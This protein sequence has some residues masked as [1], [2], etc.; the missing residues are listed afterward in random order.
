MYNVS[1]KVL[2]LLFAPTN[3]L[4]SFA[5]AHTYLLTTSYLV[6]YERVHTVRFTFCVKYLKTH[7][8]CTCNTCSFQRTQPIIMDNWRGHESS[9]SKRGSFGRDREIRVRERLIFPNIVHSWCMLVTWLRIHSNRREKL[10]EK[11]EKGTS[12][13]FS[14]F[15]FVLFHASS[16]TRQ[17]IKEAEYGVNTGAFSWRDFKLLPRHSFSLRLKCS[18]CDKFEISWNIFSIISLN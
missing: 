18:L 6:F 13:R 15:E 17:F 1:P 3:F 9:S 10:R 16:W 12:R 14:S 8:I 11:G 2:M 4:T 5:R 7:F